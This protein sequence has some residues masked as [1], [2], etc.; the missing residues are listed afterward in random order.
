VIFAQKALSGASPTA[1][2]WR[3]VVA[4]DQT[5]VQLNQAFKTLAVICDK[6]I[7]IELLEAEKNGYPDVRRR[8]DRSFEIL[9][10]L[11]QQLEA[12]LPSLPI[13]WPAPRG[14]LRLAGRVFRRYEYVQGQTLAARLLPVAYDHHAAAELF[15][16]AVAGY[17][18]LCGRLSAC[19]QS[20]TSE[21]NWPRIKAQLDGITVSDDIRR[22]FELAVDVAMKAG[23]TLSAVHGD[24]TL[25]NLIVSPSGELVLV[26]WEHVVPAYPIGADLVRFFEDAMQE[27]ARLG[28]RKQRLFRTHLRQV[29]GAA[30]QTCGYESKDYRYLHAFYVGQQIAAF[31]GEGRVHPPLLQ[32]YR[33]G[34][35]PESF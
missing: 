16:R 19:L 14:S 31:G 27:S 35:F 15:E 4:P 3:E 32:A 22:D 34:G 2:P 24:F 28:P 7:P 5:V 21:S 9:C 12:E 30:L 18:S 33:S 11:Q 20:S 25:G 6:G 10:S 23:W 8:L 26:D 17:I 1:M 13:R 29:L